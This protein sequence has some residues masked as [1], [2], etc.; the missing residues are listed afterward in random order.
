M[1]VALGGSLLIDIASD[2]PAAE[3]H[4]FYPDLPWNLLAHAVEIV[5][6]SRLSRA[7]GMTR[8][9]VNSLHH[10]ACDVIGDGLQVVACAPDGI[11]EGLEVDDGAHPF[12][13]GVQWHPE[14][15]SERPET[16]QLFSAFVGAAHNGR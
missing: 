15:L 9:E 1:N 4:S 2:R 14:W 11:V 10:Q 6:N 5:P 7:I 8:L 16:R 3:K 13:V 12:G